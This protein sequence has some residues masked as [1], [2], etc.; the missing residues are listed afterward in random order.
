MIREYIHKIST[1]GGLIKVLLMSILQQFL[2][3]LHGH[4]RISG[5]QKFYMWTQAFQF[6]DCCF[7]N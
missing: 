6:A 7:C 3:M 5:G 4:M 2:Q 1:F